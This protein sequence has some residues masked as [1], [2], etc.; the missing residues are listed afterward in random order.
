MAVTKRSKNHANEESY[1]ILSGATVLKTSDTFVNHERR[2]DEYCLTATTNN[3]Y[4][5]KIIDSY[6][7]S[8]TNGAWVSVSGLYGNVVLKA[9]L[10]EER[11]ELYALSLYYPVMKS[12]EWKMTATSGSIASDWYAVNFGESGWSAV[13]LGSV[14]TPATG[15]QYFRKSFAGIANM[16]AYEVEL[17]Y[18]FGMILYV[19]GVEVFRDHMA[20]GVVSPSTASVGAYET[21]G[22]HGV[23]RPAAEI[24]AGNSVLAVELHFPAGTTSAAVDFNAYVAAVASSTPIVENTKCY[25]YPYSVT[26][27]ATGGTNPGNIFNF[28]RTDYYY[29]AATVLP[30]TVT[31]EL[32]GPRA[33]INGL[34][35]WPYTYVTQSP[36]TFTLSGAVSSSS[37][38]TNV[39]ST[40]GTSYTSSTYKMLYG[41]F[42]AKP[43]QSYRLLVSSAVSTT[44]VYAVEAQLVTC[45]DLLPTGITFN[46]STYSVYSGYESVS[47]RPEN[48]EFTS[49]SVAP[50]LPSGL[51]LDSTTCLISGTPSAALTQT[52]FTMTSVMG[53]QNYQGTFSLQALSC[54]ATLTKVLRTYKTN[55][56]YESFSIKDTATQQVVLN[57]A[58]N[59][60]QVNSVDWTAV[61][62]LTGSKYEID[63]GSSINYWQSTSFLYVRAMLSGDEYETIARVRYDVN[64]GLAQDR[65]IN[66]QWSVTPHAQWFYKMSEVPANWFG[67][68]TSGWSTGSMGG[69]SGATNQIQLYKQT[70]NVAS[71]NE[72]SGLVISLRY[73][74]GCVIYLNGHEAFRNGVNGEVSTSS[75]GLNAYTNILYHQISLPKKTMAVGETAAVDYL[76]EGANT[77]AIAVVA[78]MASQTSSVFDCAVRLMIGSDSRVFDYTVS[79][80]GINGSPSTMANQYYGYNVYYST[81]N[82]NYWT[83]TFSNDRREWLSAVTVYL[84]YTQST[85]Q[86]GQFSVLGRNTNLEEWTLIKNVTGMTWSLAGE[87]KK[88]WLENSKPYNQY[89]FENF[90]SGN[91]SSCYWKFSTLDLTADAIPASIPE[92]A[93]TTPLIINKDIEMG[94]VY[95]NSDYYYDFSVS[96]ALPTGISI[97]PNTGKISGT[98]STLMTATTY[99]ITAK[100]YGGGSS[101]AVVTISV[102]TCFGGKSLITLVARLDGWPEEGSY[103]LFSGKGTSG[104][105]VASNTAFQV[106]SG[107][108]YADFCV[109]HNIYT[110]V[111]YDSKSDGWNNPAGWYLTVDVGEMVFDMGQFPRSTPSISTMFSSLLPFQIE[112]DSWKVWNTGEAAASGWNGKDFN[113]SAW[114]TKKAAELGNHMGTTAYIRHEVNIPSLDDY[115][116]LNVRVKYTGGVAAYFNGHL[117]ARFNLE[118]N[119]DASTGAV[120]AHD[121]SLFS[122]FHVVLSTAGAVSGKNVMAFEIHRASGQSAV[123][124]DATAVFGVNDCSIVV[125]SFSS[126]S[127]STVSGCTKEELLDLKPTT[128]GNIPNAENAYL[129]WVVENLE[130]SRFNSFALQ[131][132]TARTGYD[133][134]VYGRWETTDE[135]TSALAVTGQSTKNMDRSAWAMPVGM[136]GFSQFR[137]VVDYIAS[138]TVSTNAYVMQY[139][140]PSG[141]GTCPAVGEYPAVG[142]GEISP[143]KC[144][145][146]F[147]GYSYRICT[148]GVLGDVLNDKCAYK[149]PA[150]INYRNN[151]MQFIMDTEVSSGVPTYRNIIQEFYM[152]T[153]T[154][155]PEG[156]RI[157]R[158]TGEIKGIPRATLDSRSYTVRGKNPA[159]ESF[160]AITISVRKGYCA[161]EGVFERTS[162]GETVVYDCTLKGDYTGYERRACV[163]GKKNGEWQILESCQAAHPTPEPTPEPTPYPTPEPTP[164]PTPEPTPNPNHESSSLQMLLIAIIVIVL[165]VVIIIVLLLKKPRKPT[166]PIQRKEAQSV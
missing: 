130:G 63:V 34:R 48:Q 59:S 158:T 60:G 121:A 64:Q 159:G 51:T 56:Y 107:L 72:I 133:F 96:P 70:F 90:A 33:H 20:D 120:A 102:E 83:M 1:Q 122:K 87:H 89:R 112:Y 3:Q 109:P 42:N 54:S 81:C 91:P 127:S 4:T 30:A 110:L 116:V 123:V 52:T 40:S 131:T 73:L 93:Y 32:G 27:T 35:V 115:H 84:Y 47:I 103:K 21:Y 9:T 100:K 138:G 29:A 142:E 88:L 149:V 12:V 62:C 75:V 2:M 77:I 15:S 50:A 16:A 147:K 46:P 19:N 166:L 36:G 104:Q 18:K 129:A 86:V 124:F 163:L 153:S 119:Y 85:Q 69:F 113:D 134:S 148:N 95:P 6:G 94:E 80:S 14:T 43:F 132:N 111:L 71:L 31:Y 150:M 55:A 143:T 76:V 10:V 74:Y 144:A 22:Y 78:Q 5:F 105:V 41:Y 137:F 146:G 68:D 45:H 67:S 98:T 26:V 135:Y 66:A 118:D 154:P 44:Y 24:E 58:Y 108:N 37:T 155:L 61:L 160:V 39:V 92:L 65:V 7:D 11:E 17:N 128:F 114:E 79:Y 164:Y 106:A 165:L 8:W 151:N 25:V 139:C 117:V 136:A 49:C 13:T 145:E 157:D 140:K 125:D 82:S 162:V 28:G 38:Y 152:Q 126:I 156:L 53:G 141:S 161:P 97:D 101:T 23:I 57:V 99:Q